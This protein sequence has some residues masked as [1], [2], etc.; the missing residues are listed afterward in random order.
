VPYS[1]VEKVE[2]GDC[3]VLCNADRFRLGLYDPTS[4]SP[5]DYMGPVLTASRRDMQFA[6]R[7]IRKFLKLCEA[8]PVG[9]SVALFP[10]G[11]S[12]GKAHSRQDSFE[13]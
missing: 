9:S 8:E 10:I 11:V 13:A 3:E 2:V 6:R 1:L 4:S 5:P 7:V 12:S